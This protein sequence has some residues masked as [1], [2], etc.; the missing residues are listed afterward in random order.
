MT[1]QLLKVVVCV[2]II[3]L[4]IY[5]LNNITL[6]ENFDSKRK[7]V[8]GNFRK[9]KRDVR[10][11]KEKFIGHVLYKIKSSLRKYEL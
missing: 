8:L 5:L 7:D 6:R 1:K 10:K 9:V 4:I 11:Y 3:L 2:V